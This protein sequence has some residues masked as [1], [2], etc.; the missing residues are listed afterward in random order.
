ML[1]VSINWPKQV[2]LKSLYVTVSLNRIRFKFAMAGVTSR[3]VFK[4]LERKR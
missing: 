1:T 4:K 3:V 2:I